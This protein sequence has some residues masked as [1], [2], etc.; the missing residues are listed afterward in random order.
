MR[1]R[2][3]LVQLEAW[4][5]RLRAAQPTG[6]VELSEPLQVLAELYGRMIYAGQSTVDLADLSAAQR[7]LLRRLATDAP[8][9]GRT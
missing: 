3:E 1:E 4:I 7:E 8:A 6:A 5:N 9:T 2:I